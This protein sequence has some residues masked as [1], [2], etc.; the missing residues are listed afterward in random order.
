MVIW[1]VF[2]DLGDARDAGPQ[3][4]QQVHQVSERTELNFSNRHFLAERCAHPSLWCL[5]GAQ[6]SR[7]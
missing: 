6:F 7:R 5:S 2:T 1:I 4:L 3:I